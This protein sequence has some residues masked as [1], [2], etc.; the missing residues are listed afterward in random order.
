MAHAIFGVPTRDRRSQ[1]LMEI[2]GVSSDGNV[3]A[4]QE[5]FQPPEGTTAWQV[6]QS[7]LFTRTKWEVSGR[8]ALILDKY[9]ATPGASCCFVRLQRA[10]AQIVWF[11]VD[12]SYTLQSCPSGG[13]LLK[14]AGEASFS[15]WVPQFP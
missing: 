8:A 12:E 6:V 2:M 15:Y 14:S 10:L 7:N 4:L 11:V 1:E 13:W 3:Y 9:S 5:F